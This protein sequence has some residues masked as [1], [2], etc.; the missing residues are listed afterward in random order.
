MTEV[1]SIII[2]SCNVDCFVVVN[3]LNLY[4]EIVGVLVKYCRLGLETKFQWSGGIDCD[5]DILSI[6][7]TGTL[8]FVRVND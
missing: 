7:N 2:K 3:V 1:F 8:P 4:V 5:F 6:M